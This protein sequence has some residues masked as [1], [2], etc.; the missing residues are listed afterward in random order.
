MHQDAPKSIS[1]INRPKVVFYLH[2]H[3]DLYTVI[4]SHHL[5]VHYVS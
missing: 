1:D 3:F 2:L 4:T 5:Y